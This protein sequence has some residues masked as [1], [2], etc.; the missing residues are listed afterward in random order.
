M[1]MIP[2]LPGQHKLCSVT[3]DLNPDQALAVRADGFDI[4]EHVQTVPA[5]ERDVA[6][7]RNE[8]KEPSDA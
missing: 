1:K 4:C 5:S 3:T 6:W 8:T 7:A 2:T